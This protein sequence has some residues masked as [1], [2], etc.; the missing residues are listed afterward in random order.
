M[1]LHKQFYPD[2]PSHERRAKMKGV[3]QKPTKS[4]SHNPLVR[5]VNENK[6]H[7]VQLLQEHTWTLGSS[8]MIHSSTTYSGSTPESVLS[9]LENYI[10]SSTQIVELF[11]QT[12]KA[13]G[14]GSGNTADN[15][16]EYKLADM[17]TAKVDPSRKRF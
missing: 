14:Y 2:E 13:R 16:R 4:S 9:L 3:I 7:L 11:K 17:L 8:N 10:P 1:F 15:D 12:C 6:C 5:A